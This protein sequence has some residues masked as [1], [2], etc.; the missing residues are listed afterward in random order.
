MQRDAC[1]V[2]T[3]RISEKLSPVQ[4]RFSTG[5]IDHRSSSFRS[6]DFCWFTR[7]LGRVPTRIDFDRETEKPCPCFNTY[8][9]ARAWNSRGRCVTTTTRR[10][11][12]TVWLS[13][14]EQ[15]QAPFPWFVRLL[16]L[17]PKIVRSEDFTGCYLSLSLSLSMLSLD[18][19]PRYGHITHPRRA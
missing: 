9:G 1:R 5:V 12:R 8:R 3:T 4:E 14:P 15:L 11:N 7:G 18:Q 13:L 16:S 6:L 17:S 2:P 19:R 10:E